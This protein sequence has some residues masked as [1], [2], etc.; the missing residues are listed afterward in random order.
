MDAIFGKFDQFEH[1]TPVR[2]DWKAQVQQ[3]PPSLEILSQIDQERYG[4][5]K[6]AQV[7]HLS[8]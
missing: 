2:A 6:Y 7:R 4:F 3:A 5:H 8:F 1:C